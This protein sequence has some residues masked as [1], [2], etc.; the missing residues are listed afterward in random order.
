MPKLVIFFQLSRTNISHSIL[1]S[2]LADAKDVLEGI[3]QAPDVRYPVLTP[4]LRV[5]AFGFILLGRIYSIVAIH[6]IF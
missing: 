2:Q 4:N 6:L 5:C 1:E 3:R